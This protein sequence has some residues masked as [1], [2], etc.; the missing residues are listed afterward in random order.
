[1]SYGLLF[2]LL[3]RSNLPKLA[4]HNFLSY[5]FY[6]QLT[7]IWHDWNYNVWYGKMFSL[8]QGLV[9]DRSK[10]VILT[11]QPGRTTESCHVST[12]S[13]VM[14]FLCPCLSSVSYLAPKLHSRFVSILEIQFSFA[15]RSHPKQ[16][17][18]DPNNFKLMLKSTLSH[19]MSV[20]IW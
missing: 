6:I 7:S 10:A 14:C 16:I 15:F 9:T 2:L 5:K 3:T 20:Q 11:I 12:V 19:E 4:L 17:K 18:R 13:W 8:N 1:M